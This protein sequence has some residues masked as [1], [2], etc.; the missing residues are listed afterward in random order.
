MDLRDGAGKI[1]YA[2]G[3]KCE[4]SNETLSRRN[5]ITFTTALFHLPP[6]N[7]RAGPL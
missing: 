1:S 5:A 6:G 7:K 4:S 2:V 3:V